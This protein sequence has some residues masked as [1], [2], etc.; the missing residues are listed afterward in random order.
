MTRVYGASCYCVGTGPSWWRRLELL[1][2][3][4]QVQCEC[5]DLAAVTNRLLDIK[6]PPLRADLL[7]EFHRHMWC[8]LLV[9]EARYLLTAAH[10]LGLEHE[11]VAMNDCIAAIEWALMFHVSCGGFPKDRSGD[12]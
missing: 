1:A 6:A 4:W 2:M 11:T 7:H 9:D 12:A 5:R 3:R 10:S 8:V